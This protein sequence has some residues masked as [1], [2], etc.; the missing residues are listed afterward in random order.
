METSP[1][2]TNRLATVVTARGQHL[3]AEISLYRFRG[4]A[5]EWA[6]T[7]PLQERAFRPRGPHVSL[8]LDDLRAFGNQNADLGESPVAVY[9]NAISV[10]RNA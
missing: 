6:F 4:A 3:P 7:M 8:D 9:T 2:G 1:I 5:D 10:E